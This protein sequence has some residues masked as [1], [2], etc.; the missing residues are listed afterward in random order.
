MAAPS[1]TTWGNIVS[2]KARIG[3]YTS[4]SNTSSRSTVTIEVW[5][6]SKYSVH[7]S[8]N[9]YY[10]NN[11]SSSAST[12]KGAVSIYT[13]VSTGSGWSTSNQQKMAS[14][15]YAY[16][17]GTT[18]VTKTCAAKFTGID[19]A[20]GTMTV[21]R[22]YTIPALDSHTYSFNANGGSGAPGSMTKWVGINF[23]FPSTKPT[24]TG[25]SFSGWNNSGVNNGT[26]YQPSQSVAG[27]PDSN[28]EWKANWTAHTYTVKYDAN[29]GSGAPSNQTKTYGVN[30]TLSSTKPTRTNYNFLGWGTSAASTT[31]AYDAGG[32]YTTNADITLYAIWELAYSKPVVTNLVADRCNASGVLAEDGQYAK[33]VF[34]WQIDEVNSGGL[35]DVVIQWKRPTDTG[36]SSAIAVSGG[37]ATSGTVSK[38][39]GGNALDTEYD[40]DIQIVVTDA[41]GNATYSI[42]LPA[43]KYIIDFLA[44]GNGIRIGAPANR[45]GFRDKFN[46]VFSNGCANLNLESDELN[47]SLDPDVTLENVILTN[48]NTPNSG[49]MYIQT[50]FN[51]EKSK[52]SNR[53]QFALPYNSNGSMYHRYFYDGTWSEWRRHANSDESQNVLWTGA[54][55]MVDTHTATLTQKVSEQRNGIVLVF[56][57]YG[58]GGPIDIDFNVFFIPK[59]QVALHNGRSY[60]F[61][62]S[63][64]GFEDIACKYLFIYDDK[65]IGAGGNATSSTGASGIKYNNGYYVLRKVIGV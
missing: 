11:E 25:H 10:F 2:S 47:D 62:M 12:S 30:L 18:S 27:L 5:F 52:N 60:D 15:S 31:I 50:M 26:I 49:Y 19:V 21:S 55:Y 37:A 23:T 59:E 32:S 61:L 65:I 56:S 33:V 63:R 34:N 4:I 3:I 13:N 44:G 35:A 54:Y 51:E 20:P 29:G 8:S 64:A 41:K 46:T 42:V 43:M 40:Y 22:S 38:V 48:V 45:Q 9:T 58:N 6:W 28:I 36:W 24:R 39:V 16:N 53:A 14:Y 1:G 17:R 57:A 7:D